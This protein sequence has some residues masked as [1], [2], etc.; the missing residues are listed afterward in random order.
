MDNGKPGIKTTTDIDAWYLQS[1][2]DNPTPDNKQ[3]TTN[4]YYQQIHPTTKINNQQ[5]TVNNRQEIK[6]T[7]TSEGFTW[8]VML[9]KDDLKAL[10]DMRCHMKALL[11]LWW[12]ENPNWRLY[13]ACYASSKTTWRFH[14]M[15]HK[16]DLKALLVMWCKVK[17][18]WRH[19]LAWGAIWR[20]PE[21]FT[22]QEV[23]YEGDLKALPGMRCHM[24]ATWRLYLACDAIWRRP[25]DFTWHVMPYYEEDLKALPGMRCHLKRT[26]MLYLAIDVI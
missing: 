15:P 11:D 26:W 22:W 24:K 17:R 13:L 21:G 16:D 5:P 9:S 7:K 25:G 4:N 2:L 18:T 8:H 10:P 12:Q 20:R 14:V 23:P 6:Y 3:L 19:Y 1:A